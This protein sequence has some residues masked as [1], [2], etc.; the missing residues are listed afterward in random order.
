MNKKKILIVTEALSYGGN[1]VVAMNIEK[2]LNREIYECTY[3]VRRD[4]IGEYEQ[5]AIDR[6]VSVIHVPNTELGYIKSYK[7][8]RNIFLN[9]EFDIVHSHLPFISGLVFFA[10]KSV[11]RNIKTVAHGHFSKPYNNEGNITLKEYIF[12]SVYR[13]FMR[14]LLL[15]LCDEKI[16]C[17]Q[18]SG[19]YL[20]G[21]F[22]FKKFGK[23]INNGIDTNRYQYN[24]ETRNRVRKELNIDDDTIVLGH[25]GLMNGVK[26][27]GFLI[28][29]FNEFNE[30]YSNS[31]LMLVG[32]GPKLEEFKS[33]A[34]TLPCSDKILFLALFF[35]L[36]MKDFLLLS[37]KHKQ[38]CCL[39]LFLE[40]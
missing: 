30:K 18:K 15:F 9:E 34:L 7:F 13:F 1:N 32:D 6:G 12:G 31:M 37:L 17:S 40:I 24:C 39:A 29:L 20:F 4:R 11:N 2:N 35:R 21:K 28:G 38:Q 3:C 27:Q 22:V 19:E 5:D 10:A 14:I 33:K 26:N 23:V 16:A 25:I 8:Y 36:Y